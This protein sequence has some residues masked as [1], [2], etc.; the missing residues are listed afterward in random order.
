MKILAVSMHSREFA[1]INLEKEVNYIELWRVNGNSSKVLAYHTSHG[2]YLAISTIRDAAEVYEVYGF[3]LLD[4]STIVNM[5]LVKEIVET[6]N[7]SNV[8]FL[9]GSHIPIRKKLNYP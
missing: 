5:R 8:T 4:Q 1:F 7:G 9:D 2:S 6:V 3:R